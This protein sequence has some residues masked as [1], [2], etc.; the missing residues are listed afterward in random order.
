[1]QSGQTLSEIAA[2]QLPDLPVAEAVAQIQL[3]NDL[4][5]DQVHAGQTLRIPATR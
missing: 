1:V 4:A 3:A 2:T 5:S